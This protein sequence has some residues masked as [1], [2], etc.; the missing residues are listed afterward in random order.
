MTGK[1]S[2]AVTL[3]ISA[4]V[5]SA[6]ALAGGNARP[7]A[8]EVVDAVSHD[9]I[10]GV[11]VTVKG[12]SLTGRTADDGSFYFE[13]VPGNKISLVMSHAGYK[14]REVVILVGTSPARWTIALWKQGR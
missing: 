3:A 1:R 14:D 11:R 13:E 12:T 10:E 9:V 6:P 7:V 8:G 4:A 5:I 2:A